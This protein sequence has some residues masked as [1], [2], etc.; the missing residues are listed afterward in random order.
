MT[1]AVC[2]PTR[3][4][5]CTR[6][7]LRAA[8]ALLATAPTEDEAF[9]R[10]FSRTF[11]DF[12]AGEPTDLRG[13]QDVW[14]RVLGFIRW[15][16]GAPAGQRHGYFDGELTVNGVGISFEINFDFPA[17]PAADVPA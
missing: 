2:R 12:A 13:L 8:A 17:E 7:E 16:L 4:P 5:A 6:D 14:R 3:T 9:R 15:N 1:T 10:W 11:G